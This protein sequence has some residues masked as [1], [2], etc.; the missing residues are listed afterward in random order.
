MDGGLPPHPER[1]RG[2]VRVGI[3]RQ[4]CGLEEE[5][6]RGPYRGCSPEDEQDPPAGHRLEDEQQEGREQERRAEQMGQ[7]CSSAQE[8][9]TKE[10][11]G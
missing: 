4:E 2:Q 9:M 6:A 8:F 11:I 7:E 3:S 5:H 10:S 1:D